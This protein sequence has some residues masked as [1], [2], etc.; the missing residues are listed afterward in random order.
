MPE[1]PGNAFEALAGLSPREQRKLMTILERVHHGQEVQAIAEII[2]DLGAAADSAQRLEKVLTEL[3]ESQP[4]LC[5]LEKVVGKGDRPPKAIVRMP[6]GPRVSLPLHPAVDLEALRNLHKWEC[7]LVS[8]KEMLVVGVWADD[9]YL[10]AQAQGEVVEFRSYYQGRKDMGWVAPQGRNEEI[11]NLDRTLCEQTLQAGTSLVLHRNAPNWAIAV[12]SK[13]KAQ[14]KYLVPSDSIDTTL[15]D[16]AGLERIAER[17]LEKISIRAMFPELR[18]EFALDPL[19]GLI[20]YSEKPGQGKTALIRALAREVDDLGKTA[21]FDFCLWAIQPNELK[22]KWHGQDAR[23]VRDLAA[24]IR[25]RTAAQDPA[26]RL[27]LWIYF[28]EVDSLGSRMGGDE[29]VV[30]SAQNDV[31]QALLPVLD[32][33]TSDPAQRSGKA[34][35]VFWG[36]TNRLDMLDPALRRPGRF[37]DLVLGM[38]DYSRDDAE[39]ILYK[40][41]RQQ[42]VPFCLNDR[43]VAPAGEN[44][45]RRHILQ[46]ALARTFDAP[47]M[48]Y[49]TEGQGQRRVEVAAGKILSGAS[50]R[51][52]INTAKERA[53]VRKLR[54]RGIPAV[55]CE[56]LT[57]ALIEE[58]CGAAKQLVADRAMLRRVLEIKGPILDAGVLPLEELQEHRYLRLQAS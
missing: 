28:D 36:L 37:G 23:N 26:R 46:P 8:Q 18:K 41:A 40:Y 11:I 44:D 39:S 16:L 47:V 19:R 14:S 17:L 33:L 38:P 57:D 48:H 5:V 27:V 31:V 21:G 24:A 58:S 49:T 52:A 56:D 6:N 55:S 30:S 1:E 13:E 42:S 43:V 34:V 12:L 25:A 3:L 29:H 35:I 51:N 22:E 53:A 2:K 50:F 20:L 15:D 7:V 4:V 32:G 45:V 9:D 10:W 54:R